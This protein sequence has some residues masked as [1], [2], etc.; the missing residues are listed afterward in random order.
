[1][2]ELLDTLAHAAL[3][4]GALTGV[5]AGGYALIGAV[6]DRCADVGTPRSGLRA[7]RAAARL[8]RAESGARRTC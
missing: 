4:A 2:T 1:M 6:A 7:A 3:A 8:R 5:L